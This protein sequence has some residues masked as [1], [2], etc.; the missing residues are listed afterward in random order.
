MPN[1]SSDDLAGVIL[2]ADLEQ[3]GKAQGV[4]R[5]WNPDTFQ[6]TVR[7]RGTDLHDLAVSAS[8]VEALTYRPGDVVIVEKWKPRS[9]KGMATYSIASRWVDP[10][11]G[12]AEQSIA[13]L[14]GELANQLIGEI[15]EQLLTSPEGEELAAFVIGQRQHAGFE[16]GLVTSLGTSYG[17]GA[18]GPSLADVSISES[19]RALVQVACGVSVVAGVGQSSGQGYMSFAVSGASTIGSADFKSM[20]HAQS[21]SA[22]QLDGS[23]V[24]ATATVLLTADDG[25]NAGLNTFTAEYRRDSGDGDVSIFNRTLTVTAF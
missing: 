24:R 18:Q 5:A 20:N 21:G 2:N 1:W 9:S 12:R 3:V 23:G 22:D 8:G 19:R 10:G 14:R 25:L 7:V 15:V 6:N 13:F 16:A 17:G 4:I 11:A